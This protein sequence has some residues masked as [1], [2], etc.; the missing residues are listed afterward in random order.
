M[1]VTLNYHIINRTISDNIAIAEEAFEQQLAYLH[2]YEYTAL[3]LAQ[4]IADLDGRWQAPPRSVLLTFDD[5]YEDVFL[6]A[7]PALQAHHYRAVFY[8]ITGMIGGNYMTW[9]QVYTLFKDGMQISSHTVHHINIG[10]PPAPYTTQEELT[11]SKQT[12]EALLGQP[13]QFFCYPTGEPFHN[14]SVAEQQIV[15]KDLFEDGYISATL[16]PFSIFSAIQDAQT[17]Y[18]LNRLRV[19]GGEPLDAF[20]GILN[21]TLE[22][23]AAQ[24]QASGA[25]H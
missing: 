11:A 14:D 16:D 12:L 5:G 21:Y 3:S 20:S 18:Q 13:V 15:L 8:I 6:N 17:P 25:S 4:A 9:G 22:Q 19:S 24:L 10:Q 1:F 23:G 7:L 2:E